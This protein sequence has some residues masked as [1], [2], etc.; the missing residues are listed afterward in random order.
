MSPGEHV[1]NMWRPF[2]KRIDH[3]GAGVEGPEPVIDHFTVH[4]V[5]FFFGSMTD[6]REGVCFQFFSKRDQVM[7]VQVE[8]PGRQ[9]HLFFLDAL[10]IRKETVHFNSAGKAFGEMI[11]PGDIQSVQ[12]MTDV[13]DTRDIDA[14]HALCAGGKG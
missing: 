5:P 9:F 1:L 3:A 10:K 13:P 8:V 14:G 12:M 2:A 7:E 4:L 11:K 6:A